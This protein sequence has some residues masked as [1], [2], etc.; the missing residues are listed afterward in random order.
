MEQFDNMNQIV[1]ENIN[2]I[3]KY[4]MKQN[5]AKLNTIKVIF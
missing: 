3:I 2:Q 1:I 4:K 5:E